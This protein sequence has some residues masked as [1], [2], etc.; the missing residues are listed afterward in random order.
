MDALVPKVVKEHE[1]T[2]WS[3]IGFS[4]HSAQKVFMAYEATKRAYGNPK[5]SDEGYELGK[6]IV[7]NHLSGSEPIF[8]TDLISF[9]EKHA[10]GKTV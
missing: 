10:N 6:E 1:E 7:M 3:L 8:Y 5:V 2:V 4:K 9:Y